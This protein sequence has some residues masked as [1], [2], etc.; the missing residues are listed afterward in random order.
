MLDLSKLPDVAYAI[1]Y[2]DVDGRSRVTACAVP[3]DASRA[4]D[5][6]VALGGRVTAKRVERGAEATALLR[7]V[8]S[9]N[10]DAGEVF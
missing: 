9:V 2:V 5:R 8:T 3:L 10:E 6:I 4:V 1:E 7:A